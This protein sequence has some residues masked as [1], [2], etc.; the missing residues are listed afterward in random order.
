[1]ASA[2]PS[3]GKKKFS[4]VAIGLLILLGAFAL[5]LIGAWIYDASDDQQLV[6]PPGTGIVA[7]GTAPR[8]TTAATPSPPPPTFGSCK[9]FAW[10]PG[11]TVSEIGCTIVTSV[12]ASG[13]VTVE[14]RQDRQY[15][16]V[17]PTGETI[18]A[19]V[20]YF[21]LRERIQLP[22]IIHEVGKDEPCAPGTS[23][24]SFKVSPRPSPGTSYGDI[25]IDIGGQRRTTCTRKDP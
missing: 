10:F 24:S 13:W 9:K 1:M 15:V 17:M 8:R 22:T 5:Y 25:Q 23:W 3:G 20:Q 2:A 19:E 18:R 4:K 16:E 7:T 6:A 11:V 21:W 14:P 12:P